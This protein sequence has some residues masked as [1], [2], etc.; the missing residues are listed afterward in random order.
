MKINL[1]FPGMA[2]TKLKYGKP[3]VKMVLW[4][5]TTQAFTNSTGGGKNHKG[6]KCE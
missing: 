1:L 4:R 2:T 5:P 3:K 6:R